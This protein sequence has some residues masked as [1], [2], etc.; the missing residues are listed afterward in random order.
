MKPWLKNRN[1]KSA[2]VKIFSELLLTDKF[3]HYF[4]LNATLHCVKSARI[5]SYSGPYFPAFG[6]NTE[7]Y[8]VSLRI[9]SKMR[10]S[11][12]QNNSEYGHFL[13]IVI[14]WFWLLIHWLMS[15]YTHITYTMITYALSHTLHI[16]WLLIH[17]IPTNQIT[18]TCSKSKIE[19]MEKRFETCSNLTIKTPERRHDV[20]LVF[21]LLTLN[22][23]HNFF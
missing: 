21:L 22:I 5:R 16:Q 10:E 2:W 15:T 7:R 19:T 11:T 4:P 1:N 23:F 3:R 17:L 13:C 14:H 6:Q 9:Q 20:V 8:S 18:L 12:D